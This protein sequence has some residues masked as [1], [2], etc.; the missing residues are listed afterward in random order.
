MPERMGL[1]G[2]RRV[3]P[4]LRGTDKSVMTQFR[5]RCPI[6]AR[7]NRQETE[8]PARMM[9]PEFPAAER[10]DL[11]WIGKPGWRE[12]LIDVDCPSDTALF[13]MDIG[14]FVSMGKPYA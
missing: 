12:K 14:E 7:R 6:D 9:V 11:V 8:P 5:P 13:D 10:A 2:L 3:S 1:D 4:F